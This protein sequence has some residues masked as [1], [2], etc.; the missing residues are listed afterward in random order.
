MCSIAAPRRQLMTAPVVVKRPAFLLVPVAVGAVVA[1]ALGV[2]GTV[3]TPT[4]RALFATPFASFYEMKV[5]LTTVALGFAFVQLVT[6]LWMYGK[7]GR[8]AP[9]WAGGLHR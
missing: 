6:A 2:F 7:L 3:H 9:S 8:A 1:V 5:W 4:G